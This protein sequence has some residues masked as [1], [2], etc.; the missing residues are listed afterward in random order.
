MVEHGKRRATD[1]DKERHD[2]TMPIPPS[3]L[4]HQQSWLDDLMP[5]PTWEDEVKSKPTY[6]ANF[7]W[8]RSFWNPL[9]RSEIMNILAMKSLGGT[10]SVAQLWVIGKLKYIILVVHQY[11]MFTVK[12]Y[13]ANDNCNTLG[14]MLIKWGN[15]EK[16]WE[17]S[18][19]K[20]VINFSIRPKKVKKLIE[21]ITDDKEVRDIVQA[22]HLQDTFPFTYD[23]RKSAKVKDDYLNPEYNVDDFK[24]GTRVAVEF[25][26]VLHNFKASKRIDAVKAYSFRLL[27]VYLIDKPTNSTIST[28]EKRRRGDNEWMVTP[29]RTK[30][31][32]TSI[33]P[34]EC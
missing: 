15:L 30:K 11:L 16:K 32:I 5:T 21:M 25:Q 12:L 34:L 9:N 22:I 10:K 26:I 14:M 24:A 23:M 7:E 6:L 4:C 2:P 18:N 1:K 20:L 27:G 31:T 19:I 33:N 3:H 28:L 17:S 8:S 29:P 13:L